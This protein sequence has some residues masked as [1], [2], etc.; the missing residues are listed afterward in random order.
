MM[1]INDYRTLY[2][3]TRVMVTGAAGFIGRWVARTLS[4]HG[5]IV[6]PVVRN[7]TT[8]RVIF[9]R[10]EI[11]AE[12]IGA[13]LEDTEQIRELVTALKPE[14]I[15]NLVG[16]GVDRTERDERTA[17]RLNAQVGF[18]LCQVL[19][20]QSSSLGRGQALVHVGSALEYGFFDGDLTEDV[21]PHPTTLYGKSKLLGTQLIAQCCSAYGVRGI[22]ARLFTVYGPGE[23]EGRLLPTLLRAAK[24]QEPIALTTGEQERDF[25]YV[26]DVA[27]GLL[28]LGATQTGW[29]EIVNLASGQLTSVRKFAETAAEL[30]DISSE[31]LVFGARPPLPEEMHHGV[32]STQRLVDL[33]GWRLPTQIRE[34]ICRTCEF[35]ELAHA[36]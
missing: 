14:V 12:P 18:T 3:G 23:H 25:T 30:L 4:K 15:F 10:Y 7:R 11:T 9:E 24:T 17:Y 31:R 34:G 16:Y 19:S 1:I 8:A 2:A 22:V 33:T 35:E 20:S 36:R 27:E 13:D 6:Y 5:A 21:E 26:E 32:V 29:G 28:R